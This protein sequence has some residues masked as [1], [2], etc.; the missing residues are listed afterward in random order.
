MQGVGTCSLGS[1]AT[2]AEARARFTAYTRCNHANSNASP[3]C[4]NS[5]GLAGYSLSHTSGGFE[6]AA[7]VASTDAFRDAKLCAAFCDRFQGCSAF[8]WKRRQ[9]PPAVKAV[10]TCALYDMT[11]Y[12]ARY[13]KNDKIALAADTVRAYVRCARLAHGACATGACLATYAPAGAHRVAAETPRMAAVL[14]TRPA[15]ASRRAPRQASARPRGATAPR[16][17][18]PRTAP[19]VLCLYRT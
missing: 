13:P 9:Q 6:G 3:P 2:A 8:L 15:A 18:H 19:H 1:A 17:R 11:N 10:E 5:D 16:V 7:P 4:V 14:A 12:A